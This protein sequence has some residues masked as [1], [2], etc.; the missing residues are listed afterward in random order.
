MSRLDEPAS[1]PSPDLVEAIRVV[2]AKG[3]YQMPGDTLPYLTQARAVAEALAPQLQSVAVGGEKGHVSVGSVTMSPDDALDL[4]DEIAEKAAVQ[5]TMLGGMGP[6]DK[7]G[8]TVKMQPSPGLT[9]RMVDFLC[10]WLGPAENYTETPL[11][12][13][14]ALPTDS[15]KVQMSPK[16]A[17]QLYPYVLTVQRAGGKTPHEK[18]I[19]AEAA[20]AEMAADY[21]WVRKGY[22]RTCHEVEQILGKALGCP[23]MGPELFEDGKPNGDVCVGDHAPQSLASQ[24]AGEIEALRAQRDGL[25]AERDRLRDALQIVLGEFDVDRNE[26]TGAALD[27]WSGCLTSK[28]MDAARAALGSEL[29]ASDADPT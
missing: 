20:L 4:A 2:L 14:F 15:D 24:A 9:R 25:A 21:D 3:G 26:Y 18:R 1:D 23:V 11:D 19:E 12:L 27:L 8:W 6:D 5:G 22:A 29:A 17:G 10:E 7:G 13:P 28:E 16:P